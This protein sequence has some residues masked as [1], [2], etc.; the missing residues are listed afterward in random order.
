[1][2]EWAKIALPQ[3]VILAGLIVYFK[4]ALSRIEMS[5]AASRAS[6]REQAIESFFHSVTVEAGTG[7]S[8]ASAS[9]GANTARP[10][11]LRLTPD[12][13]E[14][15]RT[16]GAPNQNMTDFAGAQHLTWF[17]TNRKLVA[18]ISKDRLYAVTVSDFAERHGEKIYE[19]AAQL[20]RF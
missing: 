15:M 5:Q 16:L 11:R 12:A 14:V 13:D 10:R 20:Q 6:A 3:I 2:H 19:S 7:E 8:A 17:G 9:S 1:M 4:V 18:S